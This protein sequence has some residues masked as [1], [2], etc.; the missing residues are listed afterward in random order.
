MKNLIPNDENRGRLEEFGELHLPLAPSTDRVRDGIAMFLKTRV[1][2][3][4]EIPVEVAV[5]FSVS[6]WW[7]QD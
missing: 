1:Q 5:C 7:Q 4:Y 3:W 6:F 2:V